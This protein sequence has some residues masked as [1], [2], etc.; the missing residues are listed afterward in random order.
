MTWGE[1]QATL[2]PET[3]TRVL[4]LWD[5]DEGSMTFVSSSA[6]VVYRFTVRGESRFARFVH[7]DLRDEEFLAAG[8][9]WARHLARNGAQ[10]SVPLE[11]NRGHLI[12]NT[13]QHEDVF[14]ATVWDGVFG[15]PLGDSMTP[16]QIEAWGESLGRLHAAS[17]SYTPQPVQTAGG[18]FTPESFGLEQFWKNIADVTSHDP[19]LRRA[20]ADLGAFLGTL[21]RHDTII[22]H[23]DCRPANAIWDGENAV[24]VD[25]DEPTLAWAEYDIARAM[26]RD[27]NGVFPDLERHMHTFL[28]GYERV[29][30][31]QRSRLPQWIQLRALLMLAWSLQD[32]TW[33]WTMT[34]RDLAVRGIG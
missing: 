16:H 22:T 5:A 27:E 32:E 2:Q 24:I 33:G 10:V 17:A 7:H 18:V 4:A 29:R 25:F 13:V 8:V 30:I 12:E 9:D 28:T 21:P 20:H 26:M 3:V 1:R 6:N 31:P 11:S 34:L 19:E 14:L 15:T 23:G